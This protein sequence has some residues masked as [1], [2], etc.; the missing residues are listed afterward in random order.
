MSNRRLVV[1]TSKQI[2]ELWVN[3]SLKKKYLISTA[4]NGIGCD[5]G[6][7]CTPTGKLRVAQKIGD[8]LPLG[9]VLKARVPIGEI[10]TND[11]QNSLSKAIE[12]LVLTRVLWLEGAEA[13]NSNTLNRYIYLHGTNQEN[14]LGTPVSHGC[15]RFR[16]E[17]I[18]ELFEVLEE[19][20]GVEVV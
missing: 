18:V 20:D 6:S 2:A 3:N 5:E 15:I 10:W 1:K 9:T 19:G 16:N 17:D 8:G 14:L 13:H 4:K 7:N 11:P 12:D